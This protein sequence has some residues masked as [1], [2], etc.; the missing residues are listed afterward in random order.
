MYTSS[1]G[2]V[3]PGSSGWNS[4]CFEKR[5]A[6]RTPA[7]SVETALVVLYNIN[8]LQIKENVFRFPFKSWIE[9]LKGERP[10]KL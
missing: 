9:D 8:D 5:D 2:A 3:V 4:K 7:T 1:T 10:S 6:L